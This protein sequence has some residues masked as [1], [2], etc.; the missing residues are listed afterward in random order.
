M[1]GR[2]SPGST[3][4]FTYAAARVL[5]QAGCG[6]GGAI[7]ARDARRACSRR[8]QSRRSRAV[9]STP[10]QLAPLTRGAWSRQPRSAWWRTAVAGDVDLQLVARF[11]VERCGL[12]RRVGV[13][14]QNEDQLEG[15][16]GLLEGVQIRDVRRRVWRVAVIGHC[17]P[18]P[19]SPVDP[20]VPPKIDTTPPA[21]GGARTRRTVCSPSTCWCAWRWLWSRAS[22]VDRSN[23]AGLRVARRDADCPS[24]VRVSEC[25][26]LNGRCAQPG[27]D[28]RSLNSSIRSVMLSRPARNGGRLAQLVRALA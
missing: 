17:Q 1:A 11:R 13:Q 24:T 7:A 12:L 22:D 28:S 10:Q 23:G 5:R 14:V 8:W 21:L 3:A 20:E 16:A 27:G 4:S 26:A 15:V 9:A 19:C 25:C 6:R 2:S 18:T